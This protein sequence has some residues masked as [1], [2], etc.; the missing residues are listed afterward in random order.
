MKTKPEKKIKKW[1][2]WE[3]R[4]YPDRFSPIHYLLIDWGI[5]GK[6]LTKKQEK[7]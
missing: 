7:K 4:H 3:R 2:R 1:L 5:L 6:N